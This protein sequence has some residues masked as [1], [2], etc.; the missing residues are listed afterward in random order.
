[1]SFIQQLETLGQSGSFKQYGSVSEMLKNHQIND[2]FLKQVNLHNN[3]LI[4][5]VEP[6]D[7]DDETGK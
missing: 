3:E 7:D 2:E 4:C 6:D 1:M 5:F